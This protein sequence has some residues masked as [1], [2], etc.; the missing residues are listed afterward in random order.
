MRTNS[1]AFSTTASHS[2]FL[3]V[4]TYWLKNSF[5]TSVF[6]FIHLYLQDIPL[7]NASL[8]IPCCPVKT[9]IFLVYKEVFCKGN[10]PKITK[11]MTTFLVLFCL[12][13]QVKFIS[14]AATRTLAIF[15]C[16]TTTK[17]WSVQLKDRL[18]K[19]LRT[20]WVI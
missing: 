12:T 9:Q 20:K 11:L 16:T 13:N 5:T 7:F 8:N 18:D 2:H 3:R 4:L 17:P 10:L 1:H 14:S 19:H 6:M 15:L